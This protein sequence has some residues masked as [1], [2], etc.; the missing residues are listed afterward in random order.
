MVLWAKV[1][2]AMEG[3]SMRSNEE[4]AGHPFDIKSKRMRQPSMTLLIEMK[5][6]YLS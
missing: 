5:K 3:L 6:D 2:S 4:E 1:A